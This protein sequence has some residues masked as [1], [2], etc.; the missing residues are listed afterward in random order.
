MARSL[1]LLKQER[2]DSCA[3]ACLR[4]V[5]AARGTM[6]PE[7][8]LQRRVRMEEGGTDLEEL[9][10]LARTFG[11]VA[12]AQAATTG[13]IREFLYARSHVI[14]YINRAVFDLP[15]LGDLTPALR[16]LRVHSVVPIRVTATHVTFHDPRLPAVVRKTI[17]RFEAAQRHLG[18]ACL[19][20]SPQ[21]PDPH[22]G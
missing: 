7:A 17:R 13:Q 4:M 11:L 22:Q 21:Q 19:V 15:S 3:L 9:E 18:S 2:E 14:A 1:P 8:E 20:L 5:L 6:L 10:R 16:S 12:D